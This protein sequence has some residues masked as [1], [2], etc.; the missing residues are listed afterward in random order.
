MSN[1]ATAWAYRQ[2]IRNSSA[3]FVLVVL[4]DFADEEWSCYPGQ[5]RIGRMTGMSERTV[6]RSLDWLEEHR[7]ITR[8]HR[9]AQY[10]RRT[11]DRYWLLQAASMSGGGDQQGH[12][13]KPGGNHRS[14][15]PDGQPAI[16][17]TGHN[18]RLAKDQV[19][20]TGQ[21]DHRSD[22]PTQ[23]AI[24]TGLEP[25]VEPSVSSLKK[26]RPTKRNTPE[27]ELP[28]DFALSNNMREWAAQNVPEV[29]VE[30]ETAQFI[31]Y[32]TSRSTR[33]KDWI[34]T[35]RQWMRNQQKWSKDRLRTATTGGSRTSNVDVWDLY[36]ASLGEDT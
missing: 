36:A 26:K 17:T 29:D 2:D 3:K 22:C 28:D 16:L 8:S 33:R 21:N 20:T 30:F 12:D 5:Q 19:N 11:S 34:A 24:L 1:E 23:P 15:R 27:V 35:W 9:H 31:D 25:S 4:A 18:G 7:F 6:R 13:E 10:G 14:E 32:W